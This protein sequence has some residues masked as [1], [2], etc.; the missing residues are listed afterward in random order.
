M[1]PKDQLIKDEVMKKTKKLLEI[2][3]TLQEQLSSAEIDNHE[4][5]DRVLELK[6]EIKKLKNIKEKIE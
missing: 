2:I 5:E 3:N 6:Q 1:K 4:L